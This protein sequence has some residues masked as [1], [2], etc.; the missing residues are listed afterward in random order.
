MHR[1]CFGK[2]VACTRSTN[3]SVVNRTKSENKEN[4]YTTKYEAF[5]QLYLDPVQDVKIL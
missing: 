2:N 5:E 4:P 1:N 3:T